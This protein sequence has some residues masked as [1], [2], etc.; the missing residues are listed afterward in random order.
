MGAEH[1]PQHVELVDHD[2]AQAHQERG[3]PAV[4]G[5]HAVV[6]HL[7]VGE[8]ARWRW[9]GPR[10][11]PRARSRRRR[12]RPPG[13]GRSR[14]GEGPELV[15]GQ[16]LGGE[17]QQRG[18][19][20]HRCADGLGDGHLVAERLARR[21]AGGDRHR[22]AGPGQVDGLGLVGPEARRPPSRSRTVGG[23]RPGQL[24]EAG[25]CGPAGARGGPAAGRRRQSREA[26]RRGAVAAVS[27]MALG[28]LRRRAR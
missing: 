5:Q 16:R 24:G 12:W 26:G 23:E 1:A 11:A 20:P 14:R 19:R 8:H 18:G 4:V 22:P 28:R 17:H 13:R 2:V 6:Q 21:R 27:A 10:C 9:P 7:G 15:L 25:R 3:P